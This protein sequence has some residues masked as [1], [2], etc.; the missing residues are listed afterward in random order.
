M[1]IAL[2]VTLDVVQVP[3]GAG[4]GALGQ[5]QANQPGYGA[6]LGPGAIG[7]NQSLRL[8]LSEQVPGGDAPSSGNFT[9]A[10][11]QAATDFEALLATAGAWGGN[12]GTPLSIIQ[13]WATGGPGNQ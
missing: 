9:T 11:A 4:S 1:A 13:S 6:A 2:L 10:L 7:N 12:P 3:D 8:M 5:N